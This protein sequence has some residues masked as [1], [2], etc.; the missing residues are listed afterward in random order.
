MAVIGSDEVFSLKNGI[1]PFLYGNS[2]KAKHII[3]YAASFGPSTYEDIVK[4]GQEKMIS[5]GFQKMDGKTPPESCVC[6][7]LS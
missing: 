3:S 6:G 1:N 7:L 2:L 4:Q 5:C